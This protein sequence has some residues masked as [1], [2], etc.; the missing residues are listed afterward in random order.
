MNLSCD[1]FF[2]AHCTH[3]TRGGHY[4]LF[5]LSHK[6]YLCTLVRVMCVRPI[7]DDAEFLWRLA[8]A[9]RDVSL[10]P[11]TEAA[12]KKQLTFEG[13]EYAKRALEKDDKCFATHKVRGRFDWE[14]TN[15]SPP[16]GCCGVVSCHRITSLAMRFL[17]LGLLSCQPQ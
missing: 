16:S 5:A 4:Q 10:L 15:D 3:N 1:I 13:F 9:S 7:S 11:N 8:R 17:S 12:R 6:L 14:D 2:N